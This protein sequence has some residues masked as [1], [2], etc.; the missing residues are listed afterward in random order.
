MRKSTIPDS[1]LNP[2]LLAMMSK[3]T[4]NNARQQKYNSTTQPL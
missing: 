3:I 1:L 2:R 4:Q